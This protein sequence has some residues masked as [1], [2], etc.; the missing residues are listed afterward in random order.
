MFEAIIRNGLLMAV[1][2]L[3]LAVLGILA[4]LVH[5]YIDEEPLPRLQAA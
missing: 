3:I 1:A 5:W 2:A 4:A